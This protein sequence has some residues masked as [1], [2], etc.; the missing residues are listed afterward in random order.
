[1]EKKYL[2]ATGL[3][4][5]LINLAD[6][7]NTQAG[8]I[9][10]NLNGKFS[11]YLPLNGGMLNG[12]LY[13][14]NVIPIATER[15][16]LGNDNVKWNNVYATNFVGNASTATQVSNLLTCGSKTYNGSQAVEIVAA[17]LGLSSALKY[18]G[19]T[20]TP[21]TDEDTTLEISISGE[22]VTVS[23]GDVVFYEDKEFVW[24]GSKWELLGAELTYK[25][26][27]NA[28]PD[29]DPAP[30]E[31]AL[32]FI[33]NIEQD[34]NGVISPTKKSVQAATATQAGIVTTDEQTF[35]GDKIFLNPIYMDTD[36]YNSISSTFSSYLDLNGRSSIRFNINNQTRLCVYA[37]T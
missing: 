15:Y 28:V 26:I 4:N 31:S 17:D 20:D 13:T 30:D 22:P 19:I 18:I 33:S 9:Y 12:N 32:T 35:S 25:V 10:G 29:P 16:N 37:N 14:C 34:A 24:N 11:N 8:S 27:Q 2:D 21:L 7:I 23:N 5:L 36:K 3:S 6:R 1:M